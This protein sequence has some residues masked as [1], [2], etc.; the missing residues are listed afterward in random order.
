MPMSG[1]ERR[2]YD[3]TELRV[4]RAKDE[5]PRIIGHAA[6]FN[7]LSD[8]LGGFREEVARGAFKDSIASD[9][10][11]ALFNHDPN[12][13]L[14]RNT[15][16]TLS[17]KEDRNGLAVDI[18]PPDTQWANDLLVSMERGDITQMSFGF[19]KIDDEW[20]THEGGQVRRLRKAKLFDVSPAINVVYPD[21]DVAVRSLKTWMESQRDGGAW[22]GDAER[23]LKLAELQ[24]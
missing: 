13:V 3:V 23:R 4:S 20:R 12:F 8:N 1:I 14:G 22:I 15:A 16:G 17:L 6:I 7:S 9:D 11:W 24:C 10:V 5:A 2:V 21:T 19:R 18:L